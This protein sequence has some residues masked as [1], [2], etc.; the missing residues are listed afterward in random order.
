LFTLG[1]VGVGLLAIPTLAGSAAYA[2][3]ETFGWKQGLDRKLAG[4]RR[5]YFIVGISTAAGVALDFAKI[6]P[7][8][9][10]YWSAVVNGLLAPVLLVGVLLVASSRKLMAGQPSSRVARAV[11]GAATLLMFGAAIG[12]FVF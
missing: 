4:A 7:L 8:K 6:S 2:F 11:V 1:V 12:M 5:F 3:A 10:L 9:A